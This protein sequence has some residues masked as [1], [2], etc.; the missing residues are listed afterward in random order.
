VLKGAV[1]EPRI[2]ALIANPATH[3]MF[4]SA[5]AQQSSGGWTDPVVRLVFQQL[6]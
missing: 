3:N 1:N 6:A 4:S 5:L 2:A